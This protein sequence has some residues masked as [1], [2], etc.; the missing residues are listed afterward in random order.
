MKLPFLFY[1]TGELRIRSKVNKDSNKDQYLLRYNVEAERV[2][3]WLGR[4]WE[5]IDWSYSES[6]SISNCERIIKKRQSKEQ[7]KIIWSTLP[8]HVLMHSRNT[9]NDKLRELSLKVIKERKVEKEKL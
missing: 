4:R 6:Q 7:A 5:E 8:A 2:S 9:K 1:S 3:K